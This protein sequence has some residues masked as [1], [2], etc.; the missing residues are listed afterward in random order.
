MPELSSKVLIDI[1]TDADEKGIE[2]GKKAISDF[3]KQ[4]VDSAQRV[5]VGFGI[6]SAGAI[7]FGASALKD[8]QAQEDALSRLQTGI[9]NVTSA[10]SKDISA[11]VEYADALQKTTRFAD[12]QIESGMAMLTTFQLNQDTIKSLTPGMLDMAEAFR[13]STGETL[14][15]E[16]VSI[17]F[18]KTMGGASEG[19]DGMASTLKRMGVIMTEEQKAVFKF[20]T[21]GERAATIASIMDLNFKGFAEGGAKTSAGK[22]AIMNNQIGEVKEALGKMIADGLAPVVDYIATNVLPT[23]ENMIAWL[24]EHETV[25]RALA[26]VLGTVV[27]AGLTAMAI[28][29]ASAAI[30]FVAS[31]GTMIISLAGLTAS[32]IATGISLAIAFW[33]VTLVIAAIIAIVGLLYLAWQSNFMGIQQIVADLQAW[34]TGT[35]VPALQTAFAWI[36][37]LLNTLGQI[38]TNVWNFIIKP[39]LAVFIAWFNN[40]FWLPLKAIFDLMTLALNKMGLTWSDVWTGIK[41]LVF[42]ILE[43]IVNEVKSRINFV[44]SAIN[45]LIN[46]ANSIGGK[47]KGYTNINT[48]P[49]LAEGVRNFAGGLAIVGERGP[50]LVNLPRGSN[51]IP[52]NQ[53]GG[54]AGVTVNQTNYIREPFDMDQA[55]RELGWRLSLI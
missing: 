4:A 6:M 14:D 44:I 11:L 25:A 45:A 19:I 31:I 48:I 12:E 52:N 41:N 5:A 54:F 32:A 20:G 47:V 38:F 36:G 15:L 21:E 3:A 51:V 26:I 10:K 24:K 16:Q 29:A 34:F 17:L 8:Y 22:M 55:N 40:T 37:S 7:A 42:K 33:P 43:A 9:N 28:T 23:F 49:M 35:F 27:V 46:G 18:G 53:M 2:T 13:K 39:L 30:G 1:I 50:E